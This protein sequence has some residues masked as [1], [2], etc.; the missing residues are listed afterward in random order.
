MQY[1]ASRFDQVLKLKNKNGGTS[2]RLQHDAAL[3]ADERAL[4]QQSN[5]CQQSNTSCYLA[6]YSLHEVTAENLKMET[7]LKLITAPD[8]AQHSSDLILFA[9]RD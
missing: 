1:L 7:R 8:F 9:S 2:R 5:G 4:F 6:H 3:S